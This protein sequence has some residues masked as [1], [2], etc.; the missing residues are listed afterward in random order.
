MT[1]EEEARL[2]HE[3]LALFNGGE[4][5][6]AHESWEDIWHVASGPTK[7][8]YQ[9]LIQCAVTLEHVRRGNPRGVRSVWK[10]CQSKFTDLPATYMGVEVERL[11][12][13]LGAYIDPVLNMGPEAFDPAT[14]RGQN[15]PVDLTAAP[16]I[17]LTEDPFG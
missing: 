7:S 13:E 10:S 8:F 5:F 16:T 6:E 4:W 15:L 1:G 12:D 11:L 14:G 9:G 2:F 3:G 17:E